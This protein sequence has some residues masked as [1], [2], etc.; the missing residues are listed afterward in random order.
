MPHIQSVNGPWVKLPD[1]GA[2]HIENARRMRK[3]LSGNLDA[4]LTGYPPL[5]YLPIR[6]PPPPPG[7]DGAAAAGGDD[8][9]ASAAAGDA[10]QDFAEFQKVN[11]EKYLLRAQLARIAAATII[12]PSAA[13]EQKGLYS[14]SL[15]PKSSDVIDV[16]RVCACVHSLAVYRSVDRNHH[17][18]YTP[19]HQQTNAF[20]RTRELVFSWQPS[21][22][23][24]QVRHRFM[25]RFF[26]VSL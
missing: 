3:L 6:P 10:A 7:S 15:S 20:I 5:A 18:I 23:F 11:T 12:S 8:A 1:I 21:C 25:G 13:Y 17:Q 9:D 19:T 2:A 26:M 24:I 22:N 4:P 14:F 16:I